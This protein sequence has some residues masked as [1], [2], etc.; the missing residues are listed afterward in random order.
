MAV[1][2][3]QGLERGTGAGQSIGNRWLIAIMG[4][5]LQMCLGTVY[6]WSIFKKPFQDAYGWSASEVQ[7]AFAAAICFLGL[8]AAIG[9]VVLP[10]FGPRKLAVTGGLLFGIGYLVAAAGLGQHSLYLFYAGFGV[11][12]GIGLGLGYVTPVATVAKWFPDK[13]GLVTGMVVMGFGFG[14]LVMSKLLEPGL[15]RIVGQNYPMIFALLGAIFLVVTVPVAWQLRNPPAGYLPARYQPTIAGGAA[16]A[17]EASSLRPG[18]CLG[19]GRFIMMWVVFFCNIAAGIMIVS[20]TAALMQNLPAASA[21]RLSVLKGVDLGDSSAVATTLKATGAML[22]AISSI[23]NGLGRFFWGGLSDR[24][25]RVMTFRIMLLTQAAAFVGLMLVGDLYLFGALVCYILLCYGGGFGT[26]PSFVLDVF[27]KRMM[28]IVYG[29]ILTAWSAGAVV[30]PMAYGMIE[31]WSKHGGK[32]VPHFVDSLL[33]GLSRANWVG[34]LSGNGPVATC[35]FIAAV[36]LLL[37]GLA[38]SL[39]I[40]NKQFDA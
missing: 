7:L 39:A 21:L 2:F 22:V 28:A 32:G 19:S 12:G 31:D 16:A 35:A 8:A 27:G 14:A 26:M 13:K 17:T 25:G 40:S 9:G 20:T 37:V 4:T 30:G 36:V 6:A 23:F 29:V 5:V 11:I 24:I 38:A 3:E 10:R 18:Q 34:P 1:T 33:Q 15:E